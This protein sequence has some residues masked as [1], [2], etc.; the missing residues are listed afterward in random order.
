M[1]VIRDTPRAEDV[2]RY[3]SPRRPVIHEDGA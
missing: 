3:R 2:A 1:P